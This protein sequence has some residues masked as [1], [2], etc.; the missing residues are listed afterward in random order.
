M[1][2][3]KVK[4]RKTNLFFMES[5]HLHA[6]E[7]NMLVEDSKPLNEFSLVVGTTC[8]RKNVATRWVRTI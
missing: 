6:P 5:H 2:A 4:Q 3:R 8:N 1:L 7:A